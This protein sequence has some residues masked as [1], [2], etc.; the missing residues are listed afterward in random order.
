[1][2]TEEYQQL[3]LVES[4]DLHYSVMQSV[5]VL[6][7]QTGGV[8]KLG[9]LLNVVHEHVNSVLKFKIRRSWKEVA[10][11][12]DG[13]QETRSWGRRITG[14]HEMWEFWV[15]NF[16]SQF[17][18]LISFLFAPADRKQCLNVHVNNEIKI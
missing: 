14:P 12:Q 16:Y 2:H 5:L 3:T 8:D 17:S 6:R 4:L 11:F 1:M 9:G 13:R 15:L 18:P 7:L 10:A